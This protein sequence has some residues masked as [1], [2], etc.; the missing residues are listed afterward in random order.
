SYTKLGQTYVRQARETGDLS[1]YDRAEAALT[2]ALEILPDHL[3]A[4]AAL[5]G[6]HFALHDFENAL[7][8][9]EQVYAADPSATQALAVIADAHLTLGNYEE[10]RAAY[11]QLDAAVDGPPVDSRRSHVAYLDGDAGRAIDLMEQAVEGSTGGNQSV[12]S[13]AWYRAQLARLYL[14]TGRYDDAERWFAE[15]LA[16][17]PGYPLALAGLGAVEAAR[18]DDEEAVAYYE[19]AVAAVP[20]P[21]WLAAL[22]DLYARAGDTEAARKQYET[23]EFI[24]ELAEVNRVV[25]NRELALFYADHEINTSTAVDL[26]LR[27]LEVRRDIYGFDAA[28]WALYKDGR[29]DEA[30]PLMEQ[31]LSL[32][33]ED[34]RL[35]FH[36]GLISR[37]V[38]D[39]ELARAHLERALDISPHFSVLYEPEARQ[40][41]TALDAERELAGAGGAR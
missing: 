3:D 37:A 13:I 35:L 4:Q 10:A 40:A 17:L 34:P 38:G 22:G 12:E 28:A 39:E 2:K 27:E 41:L 5:A 29:A 25:Y 6:V 20:Q 14:D 7:A 9:A 32:G 24:G 21:S 30:A 15:A 8:L 23:V 16:T 26:A 31:A 33:T 36:A 19:R 11:A 1:A 18:G